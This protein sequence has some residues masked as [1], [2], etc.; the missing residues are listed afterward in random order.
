[1]WVK[2]T[3]GKLL[4][5]VFEATCPLCQRST[6]QA[7][8][9]DCQRQVQRCQ[10]TVAE[11]YQPTP[12]PLFAWGSYGGALKRTIAALKYENHPELARPLAHWM[13][14]AW[15][16]SPVRT[17]R[18]IVVPI[19]MHPDKKR[20]RGFNQAELLAQGFC[21]L[22]GLP[23]EPLGLERVRATEAQFKLSTNQRQENLADAFTPGSS[24][25]RRPPAHS[26][27]LLDDIYTTG[28]TLQSAAQTLRRRGIRV[29]G[30]IV[31]ARAAMGRGEGEGGR[32][33]K[34]EL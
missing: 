5:L 19:P 28:A 27:L 24:L 29:Q 34:G 32:G 16:A 9:L 2:A 20:K 1:M 12:L 33:G 8:C 18:A 3:I 30:A 17:E 22:T 26:I 14:Q 11:Q 6:A 13:A 23:L 7:F 31:L 4:G 25:L 21:D 10:L 15:L